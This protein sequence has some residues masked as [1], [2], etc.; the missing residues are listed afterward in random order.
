MLKLKAK[1][2]SLGSNDNVATHGAAENALAAV[3]SSP[4]SSQLA[5]KLRAAEDDLSATSDQCQ[6][7][8][9]LIVVARDEAAKKDEE[10]DSLKQQVARLER[11]LKTTREI[12]RKYLTDLGRHEDEIAVLCGFAEDH[13]DEQRKTAVAAPPGSATEEA[14]P[15]T[16]SDI[17]AQITRTCA[18]IQQQQ[19]Q[20]GIRSRRHPLRSYFRPVLPSCSLRTRRRPCAAGPRSR[21][22]GPRIQRAVHRHRARARGL[23]AATAAAAAEGEAAVPA[24]PADID[25]EVE[26]MRAMFGF[27]GLKPSASSCDV[28]AAGNGAAARPPLPR[29]AASSP[30]PQAMARVASPSPS[31][32]PAAGPSP[33]PPP[34]PALVVEAEAE[35]EAAGASDPVD[36]LRAKFGMA[37]DAPG[38][39]SSSPS[40]RPPPLPRTRT[41]RPAPDPA[42]LSPSASPVPPADPAP[43]APPPPP[44]RT[45]SGDDELEKMRAMFGFGGLK[46]K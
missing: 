3:T 23:H 33:S 7:L 14:R 15:V 38:S 24:P 1:L 18:G 43:P 46:P 26:K 35:A 22:A 20:Q 19:Q 44:P 11:E 25:P 39:R 21:A 34:A 9:Q 30:V 37:V 10:I 40:A 8:S 27:G 4:S 29:S 13:P 2:K 36:A 28:A 41:R 12:F 31:S 5:A 42:P 6:V 45:G 17:M 16:D 32:S